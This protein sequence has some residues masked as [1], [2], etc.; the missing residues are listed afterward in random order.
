MKSLILTTETK[1][2][3][4]TVPNTFLDNFMPEANGEFVKI[5]L[6]LLRCIS[7]SGM[8]ISVSLLADKFNHTEN[9]VIRSLRYWEKAGL[10]SLTYTSDK[11][12]LAGI[13]LLSLHDSEDAHDVFHHDNNSNHNGNGNNGNI[14]GKVYNASSAEDFTDSNRSIISNSVSYDAP[15]ADVPII[16]DSVSERKPKPVYTSTQLKAF[17]QKEELSQLLYIA[18]KYLGKTL[19]S[20]ETNSIIYFYETLKFPSDLI[21]YLIEFC[22]SREHRSMRYIEKVAL[23]WADSGIGSVSQAKKEVVLH[24]T[25]VYSVMK[26][27]GISNRNPGIREQE[28]ISKWNDVYCFDSEIIVEACNRTIQVTHQPSFEYADSIL[29]KWKEKN[30]TRLSELKALDEQFAQSKSSKERIVSP[31]ASASSSNNKFNNFPQRNYDF[32]ELEKQ[33]LG[34]NN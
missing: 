33:L 11:K 1:S 21:E 25:N 4:I 13:T 14:P 17:A 27:F 26:A 9:D 34:N 5:Y 16:V 15:N 31:K 29:T 32:D 6:Y 30:I 22:V 18:Q 20:T 8:N 7:D 28:F 23:S 12:E 19:T 2:H 3:A 10:I 24:S